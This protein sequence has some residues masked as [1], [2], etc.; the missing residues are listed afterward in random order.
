VEASTSV[1]SPTARNPFRLR[2]AP[3]RLSAA[4]TQR[5]GAEV[6]RCRRAPRRDLLRRVRV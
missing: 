3:R 5:Y 6:L 1:A 2:R 4:R